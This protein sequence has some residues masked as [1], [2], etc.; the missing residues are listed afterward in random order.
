MVICNLFNE[1]FDVMCVFLVF[2]LVCNLLYNY[3]YGVVCGCL[4]EVGFVFCK[5]LDG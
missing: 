1:E 5:G 2:G 4:F 3:C